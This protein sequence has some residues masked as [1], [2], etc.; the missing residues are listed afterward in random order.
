M[1]GR[2]LVLQKANQPGM[3]DLGI[4]DDLIGLM[5]GA[6]RK[7]PGPG[8]VLDQYLDRPQALRSAQAAARKG[9]N[10][11]SPDIVRGVRSTP[12]MR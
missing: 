6:I 8:Q 12:S 11:C 3:D 10:H 1:L 2:C 9:D 5:I 4:R 7:Y